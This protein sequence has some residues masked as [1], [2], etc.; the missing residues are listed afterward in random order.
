MAVGILPNCSG[1]AH[2]QTGAADILVGIVA[3]LAEPEPG[4]AASG[5]VSISVSCGSGDAIAGGNM[6]VTAGDS[7]NDDGVGGAVSLLAGDG[8]AEKGGAG[9]HV[10][11]Q[12][13]EA[14]GEK[15]TN[16]GGEMTLAA[17]KALAPP[18]GSQRRTPGVGT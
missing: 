17:G 12:A 4:A 18:R 2:L 8:T 10:S 7:S 6:L 16:H 9:G 11:I 15:A 1:S 13:G 14:K 3:A 5:R